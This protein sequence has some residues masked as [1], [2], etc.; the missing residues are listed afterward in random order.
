MSDKPSTPD[1]EAARKKVAALSPALMRLHKALI[2]SEKEGYEKYFGTVKTAGQFLHLLTSDPY[3][4]WLRPLSSLIALIDETLDADEPVT[5]SV[6]A[7]ISNEVRTMLTP[8]EE[9]DGFARRYFDA[10]QR[11]PEVVLA[12]GEVMKL[13]GPAGKQ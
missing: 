6:T 5:K 12:H 2:Q 13:I 8:D 9:G 4:A 3:F 7:A 1:D 11:E 10:M